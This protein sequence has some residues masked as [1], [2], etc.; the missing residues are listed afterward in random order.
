MLHNMWQKLDADHSGRVSMDEF[1]AFATQHIKRKLAHGLP[2]FTNSPHV[3]SLS[4]TLQL[5]GDE[6][7]ENLVSRI[8][9]KVELQLFGKKSSFTLE[10]MMRRIWLRARPPHLKRMKAWCHEMLEERKRT[11]V[12]T[13]PVLSVTDFG[14]LCSVFKHFD[15]AGSGEIK[16]DALVEKGLIYRDQ[17]D[18]CKQEWDANG[19]GK[20]DMLE[21]CDMMCPAGW[22]AHRES[23]IATNKDGHRISFDNWINGWH[24]EKAGE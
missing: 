22:R 18:L 9:D 8:C 17:V 4:A 10:D 23:K 16:L 12:G 24:K 13:P 14:D 19:D 11:R 3:P 15:D 20:L 2:P 1:R 7:H 21:F 5:R 6:G